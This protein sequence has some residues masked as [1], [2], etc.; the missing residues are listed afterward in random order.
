ARSRR[1]Q[2]LRRRL[3]PD[4]RHR[5]HRLVHRRRAVAA[6]D[7]LSGARSAGSQRGS[8]MIRSYTAAWF[9]AFALSASAES[10]SDFAYRIPLV[11]RGDAAFFRVE[12]PPP[13]YEGAVRRDLG[14]LR[15]FNGDGS[16]VAFAFLPRPALTREA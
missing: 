8:A 6:A 11:T 3:V 12:L 13:V 14:D 4:R 16:P 5:A 9:A 15:I 1:R 2:A 7:R 10:P